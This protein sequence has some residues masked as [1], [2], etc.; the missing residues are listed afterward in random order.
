[1]GTKPNEVEANPT[2]E[3]NSSTLKQPYLDGD[4]AQ[5]R[6]NTEAEEGEEEQIRADIERTRAGLSQT[7]DALQEKLAPERIIDQ[8]K[9]K[10][11]EHAAEV[12][13]SAKHAVREATIG[14]AGKI[15]DN[16]TDSINYATR[17]VGVAMEDSP[18]FT[19]IRENPMPFLLISAGVGILAMN[20]RNATSKYRGERR[21]PPAYDA[22][23]R[24]YSGYDDGNRMKSTLYSPADDHRDY[25]DSA[26]E[27]VGH[28]ADR[29]QE[30]VSSAAGTIKDKAADVANRTREQVDYLSDQA[31]QGAR[32]ASDTFDTMLRDYPLAVGI[33]ALAAGA[34]VGLALPSTRVES[35]YMGET[36]DQLIEKAQ[37]AAKE[38]VEKVQRVAHEAGRT[39]QE[40]AQ[41]QGLTS[42]T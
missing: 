42:T 27:S 19:A 1:M 13:E 37:S 8:V 34:V 41:H 40:E 26:K 24:S 29:T 31:Q 14:K 16:V 11:H 4:P 18:I 6:P 22:P 2:Y 38:T 39:I 10:V 17:K 3:Y 5:M 35:E 9:E 33:A 32:R 7:I 12:L 28:V 25:L 23:E 30:F 20:K 15:M 21:Y 36:R